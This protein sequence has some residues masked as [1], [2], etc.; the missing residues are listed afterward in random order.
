MESSHAAGG[1]SIGEGESLLERRFCK[2]Q[3]L[4]LPEHDEGT[5]SEMGARTAKADPIGPARRMRRG[6]PDAG[7]GR[8]GLVEF[9]IDPSCPRP[10]GTSV[11]AEA[12]TGKS[13]SSLHGGG[14]LFYRRQPER[15]PA[16]RILRSLGRRNDVAGVEIQNQG[17]G[18]T[19]E[20]GLEGCDGDSL[21]LASTQRGKGFLLGCGRK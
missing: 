16:R 21:G 14:L 20:E 18:H 2:A 11:S 9:R 13:E 19:L 6:L 12:T 17:D 5:G 10:G 7:R 1:R 4:D 15:R 8:A 3:A